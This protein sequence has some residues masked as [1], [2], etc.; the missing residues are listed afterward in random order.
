MSKAAQGVL[1]EAYFGTLRAKRRGER[2][3][4]RKDPFR[5]KITLGLLLGLLVEQ[6]G[7]LLVKYNV[8]SDDTFFHI[9]N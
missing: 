6:D 9:V 4:W 1:S 2:R 3:S 7:I 8:L 5:I